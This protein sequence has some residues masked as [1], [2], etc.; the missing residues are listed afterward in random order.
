MRWRTA[1]QEPKAYAFAYDNLNRLTAS[2]FYNTNWTA[3]YTEQLSYDANGNITALQ[4]YRHL[5]EPIDNLIYTYHGNRLATVTDSGT[6][7]GYPQGVTNYTYDANGNNTFEGTR[8]RVTY[9]EINL[10]QQVQLLGGRGIKNIY[11]AD[12]RKLKT[13]TR[14]GTEYIK[15]G[16]KT[17]SGNLVFDINDELDYILFDEGRI[18]YNIDDSTFNFEYHLKDHLGS[19]RVAFVPTASGTEVVQENNYYPFG[20]PIADLSWS[21]KSTNRY[22]R[23]GKEYI[24]DFDWNKYDFT[25]RT[26]D[27]WA[28]R[29]LQVDP[30]ATKYYST[31]PYALWINNP[32][33]VIDPTGMWADDIYYN[34]QGK[35][36]YRIENDKPDRNF[37]IRTSQTTEDVYGKSSYEEKGNTAPI[38][39]AAAIAAESEISQGNLMGE[40]MKNVTEIVTTETMEE[41]IGIVSKDDGTGGAK[42]ANNREYGGFLKNGKVT[43]IT[44]GPVADLSKSQNASITGDVDFHSHPSGKLKV[45]RGTASWTQP[46]SKTDIKTAIGKDYVFGMG[47]GIIYIY[48][49]KGIIATIP[50]STF[51]K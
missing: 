14:Q 2:H 4:R 24:S 1:R 11:A 45:D 43:K 6:P 12:G 33:R 48:T 50:M 10:P 32:L 27:S 18:L 51:K 29:A 22:L 17:Y 13:E 42:A 41:M 3:Q 21:P 38:T 9:N 39:K 7:D 30:M 8:T 28:L 26:F 15:D 36:I 31:S 49:N 19:T 20:A 44:L 40:H 5:P 25:G 47:N 46:P 37:V 35:E 16:T 34:E 23:E